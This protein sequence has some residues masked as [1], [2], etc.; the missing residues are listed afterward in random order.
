MRACDSFHSWLKAA[1]KKLDELRRSFSS[2]LCS[3]RW[4]TW[5]STVLL[6]N[7]QS[8]D[9]VNTY[10]EMLYLLELTLVEEALHV[11]ILLSP[12]R[13]LWL[14]SKRRGKNEWTVVERL[15]WPSVE[16]T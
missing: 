3:E 9:D 13:S 12:R 2:T 1:L 10:V 16:G 15:L 8:L 7:L 14:S 6:P 4:P 11:A 5:T